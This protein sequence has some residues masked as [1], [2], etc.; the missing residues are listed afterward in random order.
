MHWET[1][2]WGASVLWAYNADTLLRKII[3]NNDVT[4][5]ASFDGGQSWMPRPTFPTNPPQGIWQSGTRLTAVFPN[6]LL[7]SSDWGLSWVQQQEAVW[8]NTTVYSSWNHD[9]IGI[10]QRVSPSTPICMPQLLITTDGGAHWHTWSHTP[11]QSYTGCGVFWLASI[12]NFATQY[13]VHDQ[14]LYASSNVDGV[15]R[16]PIA[17][18]NQLQNQEILALRLTLCADE[19]GQLLGYPVSQ[20]GIYPVLRSGAGGCDSLL[21]YDLT[22]LPNV[23]AVELDTTVLPGASFLGQL[24][25]IDT[26]VVEWP[27]SGCVEQ[28]IWQVQTVD[29]KDINPISELLVIPNPATDNV[30][31]LLDA[32]LGFEGTIA[33]YDGQARLVQSSVHHFGPGRNLVA[34]PAFARLPAGIFCVR[35]FDGRQQFSLRVVRQ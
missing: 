1:A 27:T 31:L 26:T 12:Y 2:T 15:W 14:W 32:T 23:A 16:T 35:V 3:V 17:A 33:I 10:V 5:E 9:S 6:Y 24:I 21:Q 25:T 8:S 7:S 34:L 30:R 29:D 4:H 11:F 13:L 18:L 28:I 19:A 22:I 20:N